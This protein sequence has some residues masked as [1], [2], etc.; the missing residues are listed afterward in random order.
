[1]DGL[2]RPQP[3]KD[4]SHKQKRGPRSALPWLTPHVQRKG[5]ANAALS[6]PRPLPDHWDTDSGSALAQHVPILPVSKPFASD[7]L[8][9]PGSFPAC[10]TKGT[11]TPF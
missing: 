6:E 10:V 7:S 2:T 9:I 8:T 1:M 3:W 5:G 4:W 11:V